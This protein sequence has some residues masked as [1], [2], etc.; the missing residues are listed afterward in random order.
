MQRHRAI[1]FASGMFAATAYPTLA[2]LAYSDYPQPYS[3][4][5]NWLSDLGSADLNPAGAWFYN[6]GIVA[7]GAALVPFFLGLSRW[8]MGKRGGQ[9]IMLLATQVCGLLGALAL[10][11]S[12]LYPIS[13]FASHSFFS[14]CVYVLLG[15][16]F[17]FSVAA[18]RYHP[19]CPRWLLALGVATALVDLLFSVV[20]NVPALEW[21]TVAL[22]LSYLVVLGAATDRLP[23]ATGPI[24]S[25]AAA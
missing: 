16:A 25:P 18:V 24:E 20:L 10:I 15:T 1:S 11:M 9:R 23:T 7:T 19:R 5:R 14:A 12:G 22:F 8:K 2:L 4:A 21:L 13:A 3:P 17:G 6:L